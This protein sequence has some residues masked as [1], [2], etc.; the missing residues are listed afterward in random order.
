MA[1]A[2][3]GK[4]SQ[5]HLIASALWHM[6]LSLAEARPGQ[7]QDQEQAHAQ[8]TKRCLSL[9]PHSSTRGTS[10]TAHPS[11]RDGTWMDQDGPCLTLQVTGR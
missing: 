5:R 8:P 4:V 3:A 2:R 7:D 11:P 1:G 10:T 9:S 6:P